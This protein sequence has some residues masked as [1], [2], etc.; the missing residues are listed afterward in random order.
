MKKWF[1][2][3]KTLPDSPARLG[4]LLTPHGVVS[5][6]VFM[7][8]GSQATV[9]AVTPDQLR[10]IGIKMVLSNTYH[11]YLRPGIDIVRKMGGLHRFMDWDRAILTDSGGFQIFSL[12]RLREI[13]DEGVKFRSHIDGS[14]HFITPESDMQF[15][16]DLGADVI[17][18]LDVCPAFQDSPDKVMEATQ[19]THRWAERCLAAHQRPD[20]ALF[21]IV[22]GGFNPDWRRESARFLASLDFPGYAIG[23]LSLGEPKEL[24]GKMIDITTPL[25]PENKPRY[26]MGVGSPED[27]LNGVELGIDMFDS[28]LPTRV[29]RNGALYTSR[30]R[31]NIR[32][33]MWKD[34]TSPVD[35]TCNCYSCHHFS[36]AYLHHLFRAEELLA[37]TL[38][39]VHNLQFM[40]NFMEKLRESLSLGSFKDF[41]N[42]FLAGY[43]TTDETVRL[44]QKQKWLENREG[45]P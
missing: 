2:L 29:A 44:A 36:A 42:D 13:T 27:I 16:E 5:T 3:I 9:K 18:A 17:M 34:S 26:L 39:T 35:P 11:L 45:Q 30:G 4:E 31:L 40:H 38:A 25:L 21:G 12:S 7:P 1:N 20:Q 23:G 24:T 33:A 41:K 22:Q 37:Y 10:E 15:Q 8:V 28:V 32:N 19:R 43:Q 14:E 6:P